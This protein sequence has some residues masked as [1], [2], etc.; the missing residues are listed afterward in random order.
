LNNDFDI[1]FISLVL[2]GDLLIEDELVR[3][4]GSN[5]VGYGVSSV[6]QVY[7]AWKLDFKGKIEYVECVSVHLYLPVN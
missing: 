3:G 7:F 1:V 4:S 2:K 6:L 5:F